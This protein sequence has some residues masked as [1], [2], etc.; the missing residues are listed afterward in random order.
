MHIFFFQKSTVDALKKQV[1]EE[2]HTRTIIAARITSDGD[3]IVKTKTE[4]KDK[5]EKVSE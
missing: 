1:K 2:I 5:K 3:E 4:Q